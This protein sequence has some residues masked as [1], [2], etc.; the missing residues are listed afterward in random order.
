[1]IRELGP[2]KVALDF[3]PTQMNIQISGDGADT[4]V[5]IDA[6]EY[7]TG[8]VMELAELVI[9]L[10]NSKSKIVH[11]A[12]AVSDPKKRKPDITLATQS[13]G[14]WEPRVGLEE[15]IKRTID[16]FKTIGY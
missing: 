7:A 16:W 1:M 11:I 4:G 9:R 13:L 14:G 15:G 10:T 12:P 5:A 8:L 6:A 3:G 2:G